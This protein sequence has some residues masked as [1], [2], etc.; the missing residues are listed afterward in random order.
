M[1]CDCK[2]NLEETDNIYTT[3]TDIKYKVF[4]CVNC[5]RYYINRLNVVWYEVKPVNGV[6]ELCEDLDNMIL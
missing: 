6:F 2:R 4:I 5:K 3:D 1:D